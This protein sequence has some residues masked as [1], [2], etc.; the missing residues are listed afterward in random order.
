MIPRYRGPDRRLAPRVEHRLPVR[1]THED[2]ALSAITRDLSASGASCSL[3][4]FIP[5][6]TKL[7]IQLD[8]PGRARP[9]RIACQGVVVRVEP[10]R[11]MPRSSRYHL[12]IF[13]N[14]MAGVDR[15]RLAR[16]VH[17][18]LRAARPHRRPHQ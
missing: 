7:Q 11:P 4:R 14:D 16:Y 9:T 8:L 13:F 17:E 2:G 10:P 1:L 15:T 6:M 18:H 5:L 3:R 12:A